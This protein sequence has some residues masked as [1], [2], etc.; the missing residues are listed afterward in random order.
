MADVAAMAPHELIFIQNE[1]QS[2]PE[3]FEMYLGPS[4]SYFDFFGH[5]CP[6]WDAL[7]SIFQL[8]FYVKAIQINRKIIRSYVFLCILD[9]GE[10]LER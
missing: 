5:I 6:V 1:A 4:S 9:L 8:F 10:C 7:L 3:A 2:L